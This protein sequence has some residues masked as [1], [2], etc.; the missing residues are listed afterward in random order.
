MN[1]VLAI[2][3]MNL[4]CTNCQEGSHPVSE[5]RGVAG[6]TDHRGAAQSRLSYSHGHRI[7]NELKEPN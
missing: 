3:N 6:P 4:F 1:N 7:A 2:R 5:G